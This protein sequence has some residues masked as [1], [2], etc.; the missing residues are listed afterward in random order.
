MFGVITPTY[1]TDKQIVM[2]CVQS[3]KTQS[4]YGKLNIEH[5]VCSDGYYDPELDVLSKQHGFKYM[6]SDKNLGHYGAGIRNFILQ[7]LDTYYSIFLDDDNILYPNYLQ[8]MYE[9]IQENDYCTC[10]IIHCGPVQKFV[11]NPPFILKGNKLEK[12][13]IDTLQIMIRTEK[14]R[15]IGWIENGYCSD[16]ETYEKIGKL[17]T[18][19]YV[20]EVLGIHI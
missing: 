5:I 14:M 3:V 16:G 11:G 4:L 17:C 6:Y 18:G 10:D 15:E 9:K 12:Y 20:E 7:H 8:R 13:F 1:K 19:S 2:R